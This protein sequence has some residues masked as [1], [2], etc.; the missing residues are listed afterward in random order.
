LY[1][2]SGIRHRST[3]CAY[4]SAWFNKYKVGAAGTLTHAEKTQ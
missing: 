4:K 3:L 2:V 1:Q